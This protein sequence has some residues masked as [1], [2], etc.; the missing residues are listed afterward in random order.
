MDVCRGNTVDHSDWK[1]HLLCPVNHDWT[2]PAVREALDGSGPQRPAMGFWP[3]V[4]FQN[5]EYDPIRPW[6]GF[7]MNRLLLAVYKTIY[8]NRPFATGAESASPRHHVSPETIVCVATLVITNL[9]GPHTYIGGS[10]H[11]WYDLL[12]QYLDDHREE[13]WYADLIGWWN[14]NFLEC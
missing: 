5:L 1:E 8:G 9:A 4:L 14:R 6:E 11:I 12:S 2:D 7:L 13:R 3:S 10:E